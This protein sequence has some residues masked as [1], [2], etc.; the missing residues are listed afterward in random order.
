V[1]AGAP[2]LAV[3]GFV[4]L[5]LVWSVPEALVTAGALRPGRPPP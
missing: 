1:S 4:I 5:P 2:L 3:L